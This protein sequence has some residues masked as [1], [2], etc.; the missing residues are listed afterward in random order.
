MAIKV[1]F[2]DIDGVINGFNSPPL[3]AAGWPESHLETP[4]IE[5]INKIVETVESQEL[6]NTI[7]TKIVISSSW[8][9]RFS[10]DELREMLQKQ[11]LRAE[12]L[13]VTPRIHPVK[14][15]QRVSRGKEIQAW[16]TNCSEEVIK[17]VILDD[18]PDMGHL[19]SWLILTD[20]KTGITDADVEKAIEMLSTEKI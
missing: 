13:D 10:L 17:F 19:E 3:F 2:L 6:E 16:L 4:L 7:K 5:K 20:D 14:M 9:I 18:I 12:I 11:G 15:S 8:R 1:I